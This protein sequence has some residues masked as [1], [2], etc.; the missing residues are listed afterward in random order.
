MAV[1]QLLGLWGLKETYAPII[2][3]RKA[4]SI[5]KA[6]PEKEVRTIYETGDRHWHAV[7][8]KG[9]FR[10]FYLFAH[11]PIIQVFA[12]IQAVIYGQIYLILVT[13]STTF[14]DVYGWRLAKA[15]LG[16]IAL[17]L[18]ITSV[19]QIGGHLMDRIYRYYSN[20]N[21]GV[22]KPEFRLYVLHS[23]RTQPVSSKPFLH[24]LT[25]FL[26]FFP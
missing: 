5:R 9:L 16:Y 4:A 12:I 6:N 26:S 8:R 1:V 11:E 14:T 10:P 17:G 21:G 13:V 22:G 15:G 25:F 19:S 20:K 2:L 23:E 18:G 3:Q 24:R 7:I